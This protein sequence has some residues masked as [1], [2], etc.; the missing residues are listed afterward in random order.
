MLQR[1]DGKLRMD[2]GLMV[3][4]ST[5][6]DWQDVRLTLS[7]AR[8]MD[9][10]APSELMPRF[11]RVPGKDDSFTAAGAAAHAEGDGRMGYRGRRRACAQRRPRPS[12]AD[13]RDGRL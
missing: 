7:T 6:E 5:G 12:L 8:P 10:S 1:K 4:Q 3:T 11:V 13:G 2:R 9:Q